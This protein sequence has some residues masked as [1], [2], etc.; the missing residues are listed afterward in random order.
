[1][2]IIN[3][4]SQGYWRKTKPE[5]P[6]SA[7]IQVLT[8]PLDSFSSFKV[9]LEFSNNIENKFKALEMRAFKVGATSVSDTIYSVI[10]NSVNVLVNLNVVGSDAVLSVTNNESFSLSTN[11]S[12]LI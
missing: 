7:T 11:V 2:A 5:I 10:S 3:A 4:A 8:I 12:Y 1:M 6:A 9:Y